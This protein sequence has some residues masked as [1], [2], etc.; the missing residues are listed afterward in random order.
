MQVGPA[1]GRKMMSGYLA[2]QG[3]RVAEGRVG[4]ALRSAN[5]QYHEERVEVS[6]INFKMYYTLCE[7]DLRNSKNDLR[8][9]S[10]LADKVLFVT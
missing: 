1:Y 10:N 9:P 3:I 5:P 2:A 6:F 7:S 8:N 4:Q